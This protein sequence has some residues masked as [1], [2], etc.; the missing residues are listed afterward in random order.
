MIK[1]IDIKQTESSPTE[2]VTLSQVKSH[3]KVDGSDDDT[4]LT[5]LITQVRRRVENYC[6][7]SIV[8]KTNILTAQI[9]GEDYLPYGPIAAI[10]EVLHRT[11]T[12][13]DGTPE[14]DTLTDDDY[15]TYG[16]NYKLF[17]STQTGVHKIT[18]T[19]GYTTVP[20]DLKLAILNEVAYRY[21]FRGD[22][23]G[24]CEAAKS[25]LM[26]YKRTFGI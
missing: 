14:Y 22:Q 15:S 10:T 26:P 4:L 13:T 12:E 11:G 16:E 2:P 24:F 25:L 20:D 9:C 7:I 19:T 21:T 18:Y 23:G 1:I 17:T 5:S 8:T 3:C 6:A